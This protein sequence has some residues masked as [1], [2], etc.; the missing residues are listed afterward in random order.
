MSDDEFETNLLL[1]NRGN[2]SNMASFQCKKL[3]RLKQDELKD[4][5]VSLYTLKGFRGL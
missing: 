5:H 3:S 4:F 2:L 1:I